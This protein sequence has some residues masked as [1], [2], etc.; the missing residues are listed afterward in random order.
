MCV[1]G[2]VCLWGKDVCLWG[3]DVCLWGSVLESAYSPA[4][5]DAKNKVFSI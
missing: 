1:Y 2:D 5:P 3:K 4:F